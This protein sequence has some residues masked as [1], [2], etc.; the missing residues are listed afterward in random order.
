MV[1]EI[2]RT[3]KVESCFILSFNPLK[4]RAKQIKEK[5]TP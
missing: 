2:S 5:H 3:L 1:T 4:Q